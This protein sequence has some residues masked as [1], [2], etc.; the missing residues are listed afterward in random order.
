MRYDGLQKGNGTGVRSFW[1]Q[2]SS[3]TKEFQKMSK[4][5][6]YSIISNAME[7]RYMRT[8]KGILDLATWTLL[9]TE[10]RLE[11]IEE[12]IES[13][14]LKILDLTFILFWSLPKSYEND[15]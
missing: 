2:R 13:F 15:S 4:M 10:D 5:R 14:L 7:L 1:C 11:V 12:S 9:V 3:W 8:E 6:L